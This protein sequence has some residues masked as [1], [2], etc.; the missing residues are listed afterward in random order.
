MRRPQTLT[1]Q[2]ALA[3]S[4][5][6]LMMAALG[7]TTIYALSNSAETIRQLAEQRLAHLQDAQDL[8]Q[9]TLLIERMTQRLAADD[10]PDG[11][12][13][14]HGQI[15]EQL[16]SFDRLV[17][18]LAAAAASDN[19]EV[20]DLHGASQLFRNTVNVAAQLHESA[21]GNGARP[22]GPA[23][24][25]SGARAVEDELSRQA[26][27][28][29]AAAR[30]QS[31]Y[32]TRDYRQAV[33]DL[34]RV[35]NRTR[36]WVVGLVGASLLLAWLITHAFLGRHV[37]GRLRQ[38]SH[39]LRHGDA[40]SGRGN[41]PVQG[42]D[43]IAD[44]AR[45]VEQFLED[46]RQR[47]EAEQEVMVLNT[48]LEQRVAQRTAELTI[49][50]ARQQVEIAERERAEHALRDSERFLNNIVE[51]IPL[52]LFV[53]DARDLRFVR[54]NQAGE[55][56]LGLSRKQLLG[57]GD[58]DFFPKEEADFFT[59]KDRA[60]LMEK[61]LLDIPEETIHTAQ[62]GERI[63]HTKKIPI[64]DD[65][66][67]PQYLLGISEDITERKQAEMELLRHR[68][69]LEDLIRERTAELVKA[70][71]Q[72]DAGNQAKSAF[73]ARMSHELRT[74]LN[75]VLGYAQLLQ[76]H[77]N[78]NE[79]QMAALRT[80]ERSGQSLLALIN[81]ILELS[82]I[83]AGKF[84]LEPTSFALLNFV[85]D[86]ASA[87]RVRAEHKGLRFKLEVGDNLPQTVSAD[88]GRLRQV[89]RGLLDNA[90]KFTEHGEVTLGVN[91][92]Q[93]APQEAALQFEV[94]D[95]G[96]GIDQTVLETIFGPFEQ[97]SEKDR[98]S[99]TGLGLAI[100]RQIV[101]LMGSDIH[102]ESKLG[103]GSRFWFTLT[104]PVAPEMASGQPARTTAICGYTGHRRHV[105]IVDDVAVNRKVL[106][107]MLERIG[108]QVSE[109]AE[110]RD[111]IAQAAAGAP[112]LVLMD[113]MMPAM[114][115]PEV[116]RRLRKL[117]SGAQ[118]PVI[119]VSAGATE[120]DQRRCL[121]AGADAFVAKPVDEAVLLK[122]IGDLL[123]LSW[124]MKD[125]GAPDSSAEEPLVAPP[126]QELRR[127]RHLARVG[128]MRALREWSDHVAAL[129]ESMRPFAEKVRRLADGFESKAIV[130]LSEQYAD[131]DPERPDE[132][133]RQQR[134]A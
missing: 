98:Y 125:M 104:V 28:L 69:N 127:L 5:L 32:F 84:D 47:K 96:P 26:E 73:L 15:N 55:D 99:G 101:R 81:E 124:T 90:V 95:T 38:V 60:V 41:V 100:S 33:A 52:M 7:A 46:R 128:N 114:E 131:E 1:A 42:N 122:E 93:C 79:R 103:A 67:V 123:H 6:V 39:H 48:Q 57:R 75:A 64:L 126:Q 31:D 58:H 56:L 87:V 88:E 108:F 130:A 50:N 76:H 129:S 66:G 102:V 92:L 54:C 2:F 132:P 97:V 134:T 16:E 61:R 18:R 106:A 45:A 133:L 24:R 62:G 121:D 49:A 78:L 115:G 12:R 44:M 8:V 21:L 53:K 34:L 70:K 29:A 82:N 119:A 105:L 118:L 23:Q 59:S 19:V 4:T 86:I 111:A 77:D 30:L 9:R 25:S 109:A 35:S 17:D 40:E 89:L 117:R 63:L 37:V 51:N 36:W 3:V 74:P 10:T 22:L 71:E 113:M 43:E 68:E 83:D 91:L 116:I 112:D 80:I 85:H 65:D 107:G 14:T 72:A 13:R 27:M 120:A 11:T 20:L 94:C 110:G